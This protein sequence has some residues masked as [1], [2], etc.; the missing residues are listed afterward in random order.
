[1]GYYRYFIKGYSAIAKPLLELT[2]QATP[3]HWDPPQQDTFEMLKAK[4]CEKL[5][6]QQPNFTKI[7]YLQMDASAYGVGAV[8]SQEGG[9]LNSFTQKPKRHPIAY[10]SA[11]FTPTEQNYDVYKREFLGVVKSLDHWHPYLI[12]TEKPFI[13]ETDHEN[14]TYWK[15][16]KKLMG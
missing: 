3:W 1:M 10:F 16:P 7:F 11:T 9:M 2:R 13:I 5:V 12:W 14:L 8:L 15:A 6:L 4:M